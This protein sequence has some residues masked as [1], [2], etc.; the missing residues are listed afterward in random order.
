MLNERVNNYIT[1]GQTGFFSLGY[2]TNQEE[3][4]L[5]IQTGC[6]PLV[7]KCTAFS[8][9]RSSLAETLGSILLI[10]TCLCNTTYHS[11][12]RNQYDTLSSGGNAYKL[13]LR[14][15]LNHWQK[16]LLLLVMNM[17]QKRFCSCKLSLFNGFIVYSEFLVGSIEIN[18]R[19]NFQ[20]NFLTIRH[21]CSCKSLRKITKK[22]GI[23]FNS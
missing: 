21:E 4:K 17:C 20:S 2:V 22:T 18:M 19:R 5:K 14:V 11:V 13:A 7:K 16:N 8:G 10:K 12:Y 23:F 6:T 3:G 1:I 9:P 15:L